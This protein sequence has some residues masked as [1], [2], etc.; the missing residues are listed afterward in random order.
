MFLGCTLTLKTN[1]SI[2]LKYSPHISKIKE[3]KNTIE[4]QTTNQSKPLQNG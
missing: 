1:Q 4:T 2:C 3:N